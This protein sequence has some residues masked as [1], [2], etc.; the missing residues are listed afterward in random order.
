MVP[1]TII[2]GRLVSKWGHFRWAIWVGWA[3]TILGTGLLILLDVETL[4]W[5]WVLCLLVLGLG[6]GMI[7]STLIYTIQVIT[8]N[9][10]GP[11]ALAMCTSIRTFM[12]IGIAVG[13]TA[14]QNFLQTYLAEAGLSTAIAQNAEGYIQ[15]LL[16]YPADS[17]YR[18]EVI[19]LYARAFRSIFELSTGISVIGGLAGLLV[20]SHSMDRSLGSGHVL[21]REP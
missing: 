8:N 16:A 3:V 21:I 9:D 20:K 14:F 18:I 2:V 5:E 11:Y 10:D 1:T 7:L 15:E 19:G 17:A 13:G 12:C 4:T 6:H